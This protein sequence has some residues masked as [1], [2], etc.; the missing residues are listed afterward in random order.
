MR[1]DSSIVADYPI[2]SPQSLSSKVSYSPHYWWYAR[3]KMKWQAETEQLDF[4]NNLI[5]AHQIINPILNNFKNDIQLWRFHRRAANDSAGHQFS[6]IFYST[7]DNAAKI[8]KQINSNPL[9]TQLMNEQIIERLNFDNPDKPKRSGIKDSS[10]K[11]WSLEIQKSW[12]YYIMGV[13]IMWLDL[14]NQEANIAGLNSSQSIKIQQFAYQQINNKITQHWK[15]QAKHAFF[16]HISGVFGYEA[17]DV[18]F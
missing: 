17:I 15:S 12:P 2:A 3:F 10:D 13:S 5:I 7:A 14:L 1:N 4:S 18:R 8:F 11:N 6:F 16:H 9:L